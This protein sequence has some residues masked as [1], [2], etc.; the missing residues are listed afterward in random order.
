MLECLARLHA[1][2]LTDGPA[3]CHGEGKYLFG[4]TGN[5]KA[6]PALAAGVMRHVVQICLI[7]LRESSDLDLHSPS[8]VLRARSTVDHHIK[9]LRPQGSRGME[10]V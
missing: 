4:P 2:R 7:I 9:E 10:Y 5:A 8:C 6:L 1:E 3:K